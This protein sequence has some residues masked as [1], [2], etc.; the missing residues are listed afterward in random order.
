MTNPTGKRKRMNKFAGTLTTTLEAQEAANPCEVEV[1][2]VN[3]NF[4]QEGQAYMA[5]QTLLLTEMLE[6]MKTYVFST[7]TSKIKKKGERGKY[8]SYVVDMKIKGKQSNLSICI[9][10]EI[11]RTIGDNAR[12]LV[13]ECGRVVRTRAPLDVKNWHEA[14]ARPMMGYKFEIEEGGCYMKMQAFVIDT[15]QRLYRIWKTRCTTTTRAL[16]V[17][18]YWYVFVDHPSPALPTKENNNV[19][20][21]ADVIWPAEHTRKSDEGVLQWADRNCSKEIHDKLKN[22]VA[23][24]SESKTQEEILLEVLLHRSGKTANSITEVSEKVVGEDTRAREEDKGVRRKQR[25]TTK[26]IPR[27][28]EEI[29][30][31]D[32]VPRM[33]LCGNVYN[34]C[35]V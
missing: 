26:R 1:D 31:D 28:R 4:D 21:T 12:H 18:T 2:P 6:I 25:A 30:G 8:K 3:V 35:N 32:E 5:L 9:P 13:N 23:K 11:D 22:T 33:Q 20:T 17:R 34:V 15:M 29:D 27:A 16:S 14:F 19:K 24:A 10:D 7:A